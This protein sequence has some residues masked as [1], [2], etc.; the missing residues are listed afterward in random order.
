MMGVYAGLFG[1]LS[2]ADGAVLISKRTRIEV[3]TNNHCFA[4]P[5]AGL[6]ITAIYQIVS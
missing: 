6:C 2:N 5:M 4:A 1:I 3:A